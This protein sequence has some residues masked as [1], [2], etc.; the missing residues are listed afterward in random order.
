MLSRYQI[1]NE[2]QTGFEAMTPLDVSVQL[3]VVL[4]HIKQ[5]PVSN[6]W[7]DVVYSERFS[8]ISSDPEANSSTVTKYALSFSFISLPLHDSQSF[9]IGRYT[10]ITYSVEIPH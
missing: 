1:V 9:R 6:L 7:K 2:I 5:R 8:W 3:L 10:L 4:L